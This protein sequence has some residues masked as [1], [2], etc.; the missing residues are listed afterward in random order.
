MI[1]TMKLQHLFHLVI[2]TNLTLENKFSKSSRVKD[3]F[4]LK[5][6]TRAVVVLKMMQFTYK[7][8]MFFLAKIL[9]AANKI[10][11]VISTLVCILLIILCLIFCKYTHTKKRRNQKVVYFYIKWNN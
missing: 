10:F 2:A 7:H 3:T 8:D 1:G 4:S 6:F 11:I 5:Y 9:V